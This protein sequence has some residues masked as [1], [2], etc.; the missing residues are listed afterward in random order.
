MGHSM[1]MTPLGLDNSLE[2]STEALIDHKKIDSR[3]YHSL[4]TLDHSGTGTETSPIR[5][6]RR[7]V[8]ILIKQQGWNSADEPIQSQV[9][10]TDLEQGNQ[11]L[12]GKVDDLENHSC[13]IKLWIVVLFK[14]YSPQ[15]LLSVCQKTISTPLDLQKPCILER[16]HRMGPLQPIHKIS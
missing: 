7:A 11:D 9:Q 14:T 10:L 6:P 3:S 1:S 15:A 12:K 2:C 4:A 16:A 13:R 8:D 5:C